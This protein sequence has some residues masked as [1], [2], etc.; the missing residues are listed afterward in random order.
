MQSSA[1]EC[2]FVALLAAR[3]EV[4]KQLRQRFPFVEEGLLL[5]KLIAYCS[6]EAHSSVEKAA[7]IGMVKLRILE[8]DSKFRLRGDTLQAAITVC[9]PPSEIG[10]SETLKILGRSTSGIN[11]ILC[12]RHPWNHIRLFLRCPLR[13]WSSLH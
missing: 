7:M 11:P 13:D 10:I 3:F 2:N 5:S 12:F 8:T 1:S 6:K 4:M 9:P